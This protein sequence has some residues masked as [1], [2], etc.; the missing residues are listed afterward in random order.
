LYLAHTFP[1]VPL[2]VSQ[3][4]RGTSQAGLY[5]DVVEELDWSVGQVLDRLSAL[6][7]AEHTL[8]FFTSDNGPW[9][10]KKQ[11]GG[12][13]GLLREGKGSTW[14]GG[15]REPAIAW[16]P[17]KIMPG[18][19]SGEMASTMD[20][21]TTSLTLAGVPVPQDRVIDGKSLLKVFQGGQGELDTFFYYRGPRL[22]AVRKG[23]FKAHLVTQPGYGPE[24]AQSHDPPLLFHLEHD[25]SERFDVAAQHPEVIAQIKREV[26]RHQRELKPSELHLDE[27]IRSP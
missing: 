4:F 13:A 14:E 1:H 26:E 23:P 11:H 17:G 24:P 8:V 10:T 27:L 3:R 12:S 21:F 25:P 18:R 9:L 2:H 16:W 19:V 20:L 22:M 15:M 7:L 6:G 5:G